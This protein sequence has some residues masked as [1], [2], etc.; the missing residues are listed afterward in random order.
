MWLTPACHVIKGT[1]KSASRTVHS[2]MGGMQQRTHLAEI[3]RKYMA[4]GH[5]EKESATQKA[6]TKKWARSPEKAFDVKR[7]MGH[8]TVALAFG[9]ALFWRAR[10][11]CMRNLRLNS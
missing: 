4:K 11:A 6:E 8:E 7:T 10:D 1:T 3:L 2:S 5:L 9:L